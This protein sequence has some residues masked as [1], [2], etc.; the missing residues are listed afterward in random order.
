MVKHGKLKQG[1]PFRIK[2]GMFTQPLIWY[3]DN[4]LYEYVD[5]FKIGETKWSRVRDKGDWAIMN[6]GVKKYGAEYLSAEESE[7]IGIPNRYV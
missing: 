7:E 2:G 1:R 3:Y 6:K 5:A 4:H